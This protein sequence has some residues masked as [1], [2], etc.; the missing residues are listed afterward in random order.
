M[1]P[2][3]IRKAL[4]LLVG[5]LLIMTGCATV[6][7]ASTELLCLGFSPITYSLENDSPETIEQVR[8]WNTKWRS[9]CQP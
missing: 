9:I 2:R 6:P 5:G 8:L 3:I 4:L 1:Y 7:P